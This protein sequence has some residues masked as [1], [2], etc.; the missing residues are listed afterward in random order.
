MDMK[1]NFTT[2]DSVIEKVSSNLKTHQRDIKSRNFEWKCHEN[3][4]KGLRADN[5]DNMV[6]Y[7]ILHSF[8][9]ALNIIYNFSAVC[10][11]IN[12]AKQVVADDGK[13]LSCT[14]N[15]LSELNSIKIKWNFSIYR[16]NKITRTAVFTSILIKLVFI[17]SIETVWR[18][19]NKEFYTQI[20]KTSIDNWCQSSELTEDN[21][22]MLFEFV[23][24][25]WSLSSFKIWTDWK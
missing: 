18:T 17:W 10:D 19:W 21:V 1:N 7:S 12:L 2:S 11:E 24:C 25:S 3:I 8:Q 22:S 20:V 15:F 9:L 6:S 16:H 14:T 5:D 13:I 23:I 4:M